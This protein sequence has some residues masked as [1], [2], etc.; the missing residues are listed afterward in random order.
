MPRLPRNQMAGTGRPVR[1][2]LR[3]LPAFPA[4]ARASTPALIALAENAETSMRTVHLGLGALG[5]L[6][7]RSSLD[8]QDGTIPSESMEN[9]GFL[10]AELGDFAAECMRIATDCRARI[11]QDQPGATD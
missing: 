3:Q 11:R 9:L 4:E 2:L 6:V 10:M 8:I 7:A 5:E 1:Q